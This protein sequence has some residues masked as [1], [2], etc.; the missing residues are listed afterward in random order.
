MPWRCWHITYD[1]GHTGIVCD[2]GNSPQI[3]DVDPGVT[4]SFNKY[5]FSALVDQASV[6]LGI[7]S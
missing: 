3:R 5:Q 1:K 4:D 2:I 7:I 6:T